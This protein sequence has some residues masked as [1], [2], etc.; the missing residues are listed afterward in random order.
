MGEDIDGRADQDAL[1]STAYHLLTGSHLFPHSNPAVVISRH[2]NS[3]DW[4]ASDHNESWLLAGARLA[5][6]ETLAANPRFHDRLDP[7]PRVPA[8]LPPAGKRPHRRAAETLTDPGCAAG[9]HRHRRR[10]G[11]GS[12]RNGQP[13]TEAVREAFPRGDQPWAGLRAPADVGR[14]PFRRHGPRLPTTA[15]GTTAG[16]K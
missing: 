2:L 6:A 11:G 5:D 9:G 10:C 14:Y 12:G 4:R 13:G 7:H 1:A 15:F 8:R 3:P 16:G